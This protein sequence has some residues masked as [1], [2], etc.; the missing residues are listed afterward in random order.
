MRGVRGC[1]RETADSM[2]A[3]AV[4]P[5]LMIGG[6]VPQTEVWGF[7]IPSLRD[8][9]RKLKPPAPAVQSSLAPALPRPKTTHRTPKNAPLPCKIDSANLAIAGA[10]GDFTGSILPVGDQPDAWS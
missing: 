9:D 8:S 1:L 6:R 10:V 4:A 7:N 5:R 3:H 2:N